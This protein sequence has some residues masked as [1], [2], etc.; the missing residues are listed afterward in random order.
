VA[1]LAKENLPL[2]SVIHA[3]EGLLDQIKAIRKER[4]AEK[5]KLTEKML[6]ERKAERERLDAIVWHGY[7]LLKTDNEGT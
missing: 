1:K 5:R 4:I 6:E 7:K 2:G 3:H